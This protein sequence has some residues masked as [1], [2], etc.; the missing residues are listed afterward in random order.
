MLG[1]APRLGLVIF[2]PVSKLILMHFKVH[3]HDTGLQSF[4]NLHDRLVVDGGTDLFQEEPKQGTGRDVSNLLIH[5]FLEVPLNR[6][7]G[8]LPGLFG[9]FNGHTR[10]LQQLAVMQV[11]AKVT[12]LGGRELSQSVSV[13]SCIPTSVPVETRCS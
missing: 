6:Y 7:D 1:L 10:I 8:L 9:Y 12:S 4:L 3:F 11:L 13:R 2:A 5:V